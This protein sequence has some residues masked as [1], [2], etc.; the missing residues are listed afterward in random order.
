MPLKKPRG[1][2]ITNIYVHFEF[3][4]KVRWLSKL[5]PLV[6]FMLLSKVLFHLSELVIKYD[7]Y[8][9]LIPNISKYLKRDL[10]Q[11]GRTSVVWMLGEFG[12]VN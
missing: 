5:P 4:L 9:E 1:I 3:I 8:S 11:D 2:F 10:L 12:E 6:I 7:K